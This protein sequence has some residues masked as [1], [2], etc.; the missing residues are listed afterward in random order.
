MHYKDYKGGDKVI[1]N[2]IFAILLSFLFL[3]INK[4]ID[5]EYEKPMIFIGVSVALSIIVSLKLSDKLQ[6][7][8]ITSLFVTLVNIA[9]IDIKYMEI[10]NTYNAIVLILGV[11]N[12]LI[13]KD[14]SLILTGIISFALFFIVAIFSKGA[15]GGG[16]IKL[17]LG[18]GLFFNRLAYID[19]L[20]Y[21]FG[22]GAVI[23]LILLVTKKKSK[24]DKIAFGPFMSLGAILAILV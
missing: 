21:T 18:L 7:L 1:L 17:A 15:L 5:Y 4:K 6:G 16:D 3:Y 19:F 14:Y 2:I 13:L 22:I 23:A 10:P 11:I 8:L 20:I 9:L 24:E 12:M